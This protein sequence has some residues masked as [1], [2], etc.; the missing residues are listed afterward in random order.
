VAACPQADP[1]HGL[2]AQT[3][4]I[5]ALA[6][7]GGIKLVRVFDEIGESAH[8]AS[9]PGLVAFLAAAEAG[10]ACVIIVP[11]LNR[12]ARNAG[13]LHRL[14]DLLDRRGVRLHSAT[15]SLHNLAACRVYSDDGVAGTIRVAEAGRWLGG[16]VPYGYRKVGEKRDAHLVISEDPIPDLA[17]SETEVIREVF[18]MAAVEQKS[19]RVIAVR[20]N[21]LRVPC[22]YV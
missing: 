13:D 14:L 2:D 18:R 15:D 1:R 20:L 19:C 8:N 7:A 6:K 11:D 21:D 10:L 17:M 16:I 12:L 3:A 5:R 9:R 22:A 4:R